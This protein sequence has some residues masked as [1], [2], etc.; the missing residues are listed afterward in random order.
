MEALFSLA[1]SYF[2]QSKI[3]V[4]IDEV[5]TDRTVVSVIWK[6]HNF[7]EWSQ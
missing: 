2:M 1:K 3:L 4:I 7:S 5:L 6:L